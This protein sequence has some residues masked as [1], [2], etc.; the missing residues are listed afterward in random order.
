MRGATG[1]RERQGWWAALGLLGMLA[2]GLAG[3]AP[4]VASARPTATP[5]SA[6]PRLAGQTLYVTVS[7]SATAGF[8]VALNAQTGAPEWRV[9]TATTAGRPVVS[10][11][12]L[13]VGSDDAMVRAFDAATGKPRWSFTRTVGVSNQQGQDGY[14]TLAGGTLYVSSDGGA[15][16]ALDPATGKQRWLWNEDTQANHIYSAPVVGSG[17]VYVASGGLTGAVYALEAATGKVRW[18]ATQ[19]G[20]FDGQPVLA[21]DTLYVGAND[22]DT[23]HAYNAHTGASLWSYNVGPQIHSAPVVGSGLIYVGG[24]DAVVYAL[25]AT[26]HTQVWTFRTSGVA[27]GPLIPSG[28]ALS[29]DG[30]TLY[31]GSQGGDAYALDATTGK[32][33]W[34]RALKS[35]IDAAPT[36]VDG[37]LF[38]VSEAGDLL[39]L[40]PATGA[41]VWRTQLHGAIFAPPLVT[42]PTS[43]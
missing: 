19:N 21:G 36:L 1:R 12:T 34:M 15:V 8:V 28:A 3:C 18:S 10:Q 6:D 14:V 31:I 27:S 23:F 32:V 24:M 13:Y 7:Q 30:Q 5:P 37:T 26:T 29:L 38:V 9:A 33:R 42:A 40:D 41:V 11:G 20:G 4:G 35:P 2:L 16:Y 39:A 25:S 43:A 17:L 22:P